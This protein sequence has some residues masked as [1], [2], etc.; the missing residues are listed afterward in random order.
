MGM[1]VTENMK[2]NSMIENI[3][4]V[5]TDYNN[6]MEKM[7]SQKEINRTSDNPVAMTRILDFRKTK[8]SIEQYNSNIDSAD[9]WLSS[10]ESKLSAAGDL[11]SKARELA[12]RE[13]SS[14]ATQTTRIL[15]ANEIQS[16]MDEMLSLANSTLNG[17]YLFSGSVTDKLPFLSSESSARIDAG[18]AEGNEFDGD[19]T[20]SGSYNGASNQTY[21]VKILNNSTS[22]AD[23][24]YSISTDG[25]KTWVA[26]TED[27][28][29]GPITLGDG[30][31]LTF[32]DTGSNHLTE[33]D[34][35]YVKAYS[36]GYYCGN[37][38]SLSS[39]VQADSPVTYNLTGQE[40][41][42]SSGSEGV[43]IFKCLAGL[44]TAMQNNDQEGIQ[45]Q[46]GILEDAQ[47]QIVLNVS[48]CGTRMNRLE[49]AKSNLSDLDLK[50]TELTSN[51]EDADLTKLVT[52]F[53]MKETSLNACYSMASEIANTSILN[54]LK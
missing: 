11:I 10:S 38:E 26:G 35:F 28:S 46:I 52:Q 36:A 49:I 30:V 31:Q 4:N 47:N 51:I 41:F 32:E 34:I 33:D 5:Q 44:K 12:V 50:I 25:G 8:Y 39:D 43:D 7:S 14:T 48:K 3:F 45:T 17:R 9:A 1:R 53:T 13:A 19:V 24:G 42:T 29:A 54:F 40:V 6:I 15:A 2:F 27:L 22:L 16:L 20:S 37:N 18:K 23:A 21:V